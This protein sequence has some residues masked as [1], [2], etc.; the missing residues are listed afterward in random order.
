MEV[1]L[2]L[3]KVRYD[4]KYHMDERAILGKIALTTVQTAHG[5]FASCDYPA[6]VH[7]FP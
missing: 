4:D 5:C 2:G 6:A 1:R 3:V 7:F